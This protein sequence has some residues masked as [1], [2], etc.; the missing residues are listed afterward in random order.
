MIFLF[1]DWLQGIFS[2]N[3]PTVFYYY[4]TRMLLASITSLLVTI[5]LGPWFINK[6]YELR[7]GQH[8]RVR[9][10]PL[11][12]ELHARK[13]DTPTM[14]GILI[15][16]SML[17]SMLLWMKLTHTFTLILFFTTVGVGF[18]GGYDDYLKLKYSNTKGLSGK[19]KMIA[20]LLVAGGVVAYL[21]FPSVQDAI[22]GED[23]FM[24]PVV[25]EQITPEGKM[26]QVDVQDYISRLYIPFIKTPVA[27][28]STIL[29]LAFLGLFMILV[30]VGSSNAVNLTDGLDGLATGCLIMVAGALAVVAFVSNNIEIARYLRILY[31]EGSGEVGIYLCAFMGACLGFLW[32]NGSPAQVFMG[33]TGSLTLGAIIGVSA[34]LMRREFFL[35]LVGGIFVIEALSVILQ[36]ASY[37]LRNKKRIF[38]CAPLHHHFEYKGLAETKVVIR[39]WIIALL[40]A[41]IGIGT[42]KFQ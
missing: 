2:F 35:G 23:M 21:L 24:P 20:Q 18:I 6:L 11:L 32:Y 17:I 14:G 26:Q 42:L 25:K 19:K 16:C 40:L 22:P 34:V 39:F 41:L 4:S 10:C 36:V 29:G 37:K 30:I 13:Q 27:K 31:I 7:I 5:L 9:D 28:V 8:I 15:L 33:D 3:T 38:L 1:V 12:G